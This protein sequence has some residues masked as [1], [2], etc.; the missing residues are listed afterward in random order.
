MFSSSQC[1]NKEEKR[2]PG[3]LGGQAKFDQ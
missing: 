2:L 1:I 3:E